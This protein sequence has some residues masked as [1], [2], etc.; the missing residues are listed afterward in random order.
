MSAFP[1]SLNKGNGV[2]SPRLR[3]T[4]HLPEVRALSEV[5]RQVGTNYQAAAHKT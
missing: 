3:L 2:A 4:I 5:V 1:V